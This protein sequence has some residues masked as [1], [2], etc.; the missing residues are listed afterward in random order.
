MLQESDAIYLQENLDFW[1]TLTHEEKTRILQTTTTQG[2]AKGTELRN[3]DQECLGVL[4]I[5]SGSL[6]AYIASEDGR[7][8]TLYRLYPKELCIFSASCVLNSIHIDVNI[9]ADED[10]EVIR[11]NTGVFEKLVKTNVWV[12]NISYKNAVERFGDIMWAFEQILFMKFDTRLA[13]FL[14]DEM[15]KTSSNELNLTHDQIAKY[16]GS[17]REVVSRMLKH[18]ENQGIVS[19]GRGSITILSREKLRKLL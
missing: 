4:L 1:D 3:R 9:D 12:E 18:F 8:V 14:L 6:R 11:I 16:V 17:A 10:T 19:L 2:Y 13:I 5:K 15:A 7:E